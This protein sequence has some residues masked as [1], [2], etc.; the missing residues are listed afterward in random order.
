[1]KLTNLRLHGLS[2]GDRCKSGASKLFDFPLL[3]QHFEIDDTPDLPDVME[4]LEGKTAG[5]DI[6]DDTKDIHKMLCDAY[7]KRETRLLAEKNQK[8]RDNFFKKV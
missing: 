1:M 7:D 2:K 5:L 8:I 4:E 3:R 6:D